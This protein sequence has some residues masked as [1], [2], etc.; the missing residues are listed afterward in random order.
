[1]IVVPGSIEETVRRLEA[2]I[3]K[4]EADVAE[5]AMQ[6]RAAE[7]R[8]V[9]QDAA[10][11]GDV[12]VLMKMRRPPS[13]FD[14]PRCQALYQDNPETSEGVDGRP[15]VI[16]H[17]LQHF[18]LWDTY[19]V[20]AGRPW[21]I[22]L[23]GSHN[24]GY[25]ERS[26]VQVGGQISGAAAA[27]VLAWWIRPV[28]P[29]SGWDL[30]N[31]RGVAT[32]TVGDHPSISTPLAQLLEWG[33]LVDVIVPFRQHFAVQIT[34]THIPHD[35]MLRVTLDGFLHAPEHTGRLRRQQRELPR[36]PELGG[37]QDVQPRGPLPTLQP[38]LERDNPRWTGMDAIV[39]CT[40]PLF[41]CRVHGDTR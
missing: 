13:A 12:V 40:C 37:E 10:M 23:F 7:E 34:T 19:E 26:N 27:S 8:I 11:E 24:V 5:R 18:T 25:F 31:V 28:N 41:G 20:H 15:H 39:R 35:M 21:T 30:H 17:G 22:N 9:A 33:Q 4:L 14:N 6:L 16:Y 3:Q 1:M 29:L 38:W 2:R 32:I 36:A